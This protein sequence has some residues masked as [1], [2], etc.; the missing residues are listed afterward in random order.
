M[1]RNDQVLA[2]AFI[3]ILIEVTFKMFVPQNV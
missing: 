3:Q 2:D 1:T